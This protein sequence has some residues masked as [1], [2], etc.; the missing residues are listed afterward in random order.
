M[1]G[2]LKGVP[3]AERLRFREMTT[4]DLNDIASLLGDERVMRY[5]PRPKVRSEALAWIEWSRR[6]YTRFGLG[7]WVIEDL[8][9]A[10]VGDC[11]LTWQTVDGQ[12]ELEVGYHLL[13][14]RQGMGLATEGASACRDFAAERG[15]RRLIAITNPDNLPSQRV[16][17]KIGMSRE[18]STT[19][20]S[21]VPITIHGM[22]L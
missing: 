2:Q 4:D 13:P 10:F 3:E 19:T 12:E 20:A 17:E 5:Y 11:G 7:L 1:V 6:N 21:G 16:A 8:D 9:G 22:S 18:R 14:E 15:V